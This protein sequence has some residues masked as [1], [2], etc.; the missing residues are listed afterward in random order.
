MLNRNST[1]YGY[2]TPPQNHLPVPQRPSDRT[3]YARSPRT[4]PSSVLFTQAIPINFAMLASL[5]TEKQPSLTTS[6]SSKMHSSLFP[7]YA[8]VHVLPT[9]ISVIRTLSIFHTVHLA[10]LPFFYPLCSPPFVRWVC[11][12]PIL[13]PPLHP[14]RLS[15]HLLNSQFHPFVK[16]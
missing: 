3:Q 6:S 8:Y 5:S 12:S 14:P 7:S 16:R 13:K 9:L 2:D 1:F 15:T 11:T 4:K 10:P